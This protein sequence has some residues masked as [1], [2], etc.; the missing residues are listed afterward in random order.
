MSASDRREELAN[1]IA[2]GLARAVTARADPP[3]TCIVFAEDSADHG[4]ALSQESRLSVHT[5]GKTD[6]NESKAGEHV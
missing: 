5:V 1:L 4:L 3:A 6:R 2:S